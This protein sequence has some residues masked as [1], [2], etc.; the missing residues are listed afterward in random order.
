MDTLSTALTAFKVLSFIVGLV[1]ETPH[2]QGPV[3][4]WG[5]GKHYIHQDISEAE[6]C[7]KAED[8]AKR[9]VL[10]KYAGE[11]I[12]S[13]SFMSCTEKGDEAQCP[14]TVTTWS[15]TAGVIAG[16]KN[17]T[18]KASTDPDDRRLCRVTLEGA[19]VKR[20]YDPNFDLDISLSKDILRSGEEIKINITPTESMYVNIFD[21][22]PDGN[23]HLIYPNVYE[24][25]NHV[26]ARTTI[27]STDKYSF[28]AEYPPE[29]KSP[30][31]HKTLQIV[32]TRKSL[33][34]LP[35]YKGYELQKKLLEIAA[36]D[37]RY[38]Q[39]SYKVIK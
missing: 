18:I 29:M 14:A 23:A 11:Y 20:E 2:E 30:T 26:A 8:K 37:V 1:P 31:V 32:A 10:R 38:M 25:T 24:Q 3:W 27:P 19:V 7:L 33:V 6:A 15:Q 13:Q 36:K 22:H 28:V 21:L 12:S 35:V 17:K 5:M 16:I 39:R 34:F 9:N 4:L